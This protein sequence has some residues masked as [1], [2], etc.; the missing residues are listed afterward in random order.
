MRLEDALDDC[1]VVDAGGALVVDNEVK[2][3]GVVGISVNRKGRLCAFVIRMNLNDFSV[4]S[5]LNSL[6]ENVFLL[7]V[8]VA[9]AARD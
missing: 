2:T 7:G 8:V 9:A 6:L 4:E 1:L 5:F 3:V